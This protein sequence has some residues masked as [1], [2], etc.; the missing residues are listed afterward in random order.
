MDDI[1]LQGPMQDELVKTLAAFH[2][3]NLDTLDWVPQG[4]RYAPLWVLPLY[5]ACA[6]MPDT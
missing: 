2:Q 6:I 5:I 3:F 1:F 4:A